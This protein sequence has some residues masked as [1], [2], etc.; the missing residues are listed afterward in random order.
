MLWDGGAA[1]SVSWAGRG[2]P[3]AA[4]FKSRV[5]GPALILPCSAEAGDL[6]VSLSNLFS[7]QETQPRALSQSLKASGDQG[8]FSAPD[9]RKKALILSYTF[10]PAA[11][12]WA[13]AR[14]TAFAPVHELTRFSVKIQAALPL[15]TS[16]LSPPPPQPANTRQTGES[17]FAVSFS[18]CINT[19]FHQKIT[20]FHG[21]VVHP[22]VSKQKR[23]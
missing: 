22:F 13:G 23:A 15:A 14:R 18:P 17:F 11:S 20:P 8:S 3:E 7:S 10:S 1:G 16:I 5:S 12:G 19:I 9:Q 21:L 6:L 2:A 4:A